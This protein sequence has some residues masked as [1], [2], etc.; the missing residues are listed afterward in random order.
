VPPCFRSLPRF[1]SGRRLR[2]RRSAAPSARQRGLTLVEVLISVA[3]AA[4]LTGAVVF[5]SGM[6]SSSNERAA[7]TLIV[8]GVRVGLTRASGTGKPTR[9]VFDLDKDSV[10]LE[11]ASSSVMLRVKEDDE[12]TGG[13]AEAVTEVE[14][15][16]KEEAERILAGPR[17]PRA[18]FKPIKQLGFN[19]DKTEG[20]ELGK[21]IQ[22]RQVHT[23]HDGQPRSKGRAYLY[24]WPGGLTERAVVQLKRNDGGEGLS[25]VISPLT[26]RARIEKGRVE[27]PEPPSDGE[28]SEREE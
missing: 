16:A 27:L 12:S 11:E 22:F 7:A 6:F 17:A 15:E 4:M 8:A 20:R 18:R 13:G 10:L 25:V 14:K 9:M 28:I 1:E 23:E 24:F 2:A 26:G 19:D 21:G 3:L 5:G